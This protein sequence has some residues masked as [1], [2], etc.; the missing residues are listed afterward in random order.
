MNKFY[1]HSATIVEA[2]LRIPNVKK[3]LNTGP[4][5]DVDS[6][7][8]TIEIKG[9]VD[10]LYVSGF[11]VDGEIATPGACDVEFIE[12]QDGLDG[13]GGLMS[14]DPKV[15]MVYMRVRQYFVDKDAHVVPSHKPYF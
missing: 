9:A 6:D 14:T 10:R 13:Q 5:G 3:I 7:I 4:G 11:I 1:W 12:L 2:L 8:L 15:A